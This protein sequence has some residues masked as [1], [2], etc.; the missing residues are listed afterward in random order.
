MLSTASGP[1]TAKAGMVAS[2]SAPTLNGASPDQMTMPSYSRSAS[3]RASARPSITSGL[4]ACILFL[5]LAIRTL[6]IKRPG[7]QG[8]RFGNGGASGAPVGQAGFAQQRLGEDLALVHGQLAAGHKL[9][10][11]CAPRTCAVCT[12]PASATGP[13]EHPLGQRCLHSALPASMSSWIIFADF[14][15][16]GLLPQLEGALLHAKAPAHGLVHVAGVVGNG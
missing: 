1:P 2:R 16:A 7:A 8:F 5:M 9:A 4:M 14:E 13:F 12:P 15:P 6:P 3:S 11:R 10:A